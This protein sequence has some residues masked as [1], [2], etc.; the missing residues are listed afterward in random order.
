MS[1]ITPRVGEVWQDKRGKR[2][3]VI[4]LGGEYR[5]GPMHVR[6]ESVGPNHGQ[7]GGSM[8]LAGWLRRGWKR[9]E[10]V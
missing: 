9:I 3:R 6:W 2:R 8:E 4:G 5:G 7:N 1:D 10:E